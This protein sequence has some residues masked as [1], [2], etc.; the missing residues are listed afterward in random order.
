MQL[1]NVLLEMIKPL[2]K[3]SRRARHYVALFSP[4]GA[5]SQATVENETGSRE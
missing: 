2:F 4:E 3:V 1:R 5:L